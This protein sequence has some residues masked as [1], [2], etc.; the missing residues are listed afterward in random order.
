M[1][2]KLRDLKG[3]VAVLTGASSGIGEA[4]ARALHAE[5]MHVVLAARSREK[6]EALAGELGTRALAV[7]TDVGNEAQVEHLFNTMR[8]RFGGLDRLFNN[9][10]VGHHG[11][12]EHGKTEEWKAE[13]DANLWGVLFC[14]RG[15]F[16]CSAAARAR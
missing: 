6:I 11:P 14:T 10:G 5:G 7:P 9:A 12:F 8:A 13:I 15:R 16:H 1:I 2:L 4:A 3:Q